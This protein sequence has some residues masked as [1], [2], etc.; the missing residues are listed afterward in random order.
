MANNPVKSYVNPDNIGFNVKV[1]VK[2]QELK[3]AAWSYS[4]APPAAIRQFTYLAE[5]PDKFYEHMNYSEMFALHCDYSR[6]PSG[7]VPVSFSFGERGTKAFLMSKEE[8]WKFI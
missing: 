5:H 7:I 3:N 2:A 4:K 8:C 1:S 6:F